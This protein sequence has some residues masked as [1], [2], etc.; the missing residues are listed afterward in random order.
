MIGKSAEGIDDSE[1]TLTVPD[2]CLCSYCPASFEVPE[3]LVSHVYYAHG[4]ST[5]QCSSCFFRARLP[6]MVAVHAIVAHNGAAYALDCQRAIPEEHLQFIDPHQIGILDIPRYL[7]NVP[8]C[9]FTCIHRSSFV[10]HMSTSHPGRRDSECR[11]CKQI[12]TCSSSNYT[13]LFLH[14]N[15]HGIGFFHCAYCQ[16][17]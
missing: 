10:A 11:E 17:G 7:C 13:E 2:F 1:E 6:K 15:K 9:L 5:S 3:N 14:M 8:D 16:Y 4:E 12:I